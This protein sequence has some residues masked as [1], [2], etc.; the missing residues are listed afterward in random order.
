MFTSSFYLLKNLSCFLNQKENHDMEDSIL[1][2][3]NAKYS[4]IIGLKI[5]C[6]ENLVKC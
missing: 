3:N 6:L 2:E 1:K 4:A 5:L